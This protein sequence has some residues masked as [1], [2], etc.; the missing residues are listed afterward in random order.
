MTRVATTRPGGP[1]G[2]EAPSAR[3]LWWRAAAISLLAL[4]W[5]LGVRGLNEPD[6][7]RYASVATEMLRSGDWI[8]PRFENKPHLT[9]P[10]LTYWLIALAFRACGVNEWAARLPAALAALGTL[11]LVWSM[12]CRWWGARHAMHAVLILLSTPMFFAMARL[13]DPNMLLTFWVCL[14][15]WAWLTWRHQG[16]GGRRALYY[17]AH[18]LAFLTKGPVGC[19]LIL[20]GQ[21][22]FLRFGGTDGLRRRILWW[23]GLLAAFTVAS[24]WYVLMIAQQ[25]DRTAYF[26]RYELFD[27][28]FTNA[29]G[30]GKPLW[31]FFAVTPLA[32]LPWL[33]LVATFLRRDR[34]GLR[35]AYPELP[36]LALVAVIVAFFT[37]VRSKLPTY[38][39]PAMPPLALLAAAQLRF[40]EERGRSFRGARWIVAGVALLLPVILLARLGPAGIR[41]AHGVHASL[42]VSMVLYVLLA[43]W[44]ARSSPRHW[45]FPAIAM[46]LLAYASALDLIR[47]H[48]HGIFGK[49][50]ADLINTWR[51]TARHPGA[52]F[53]FT[54]AP[55]GLV[56]YLNPEQSPR[57]LTIV[58]KVHPLPSS[59]YVR[60]LAEHLEHLPARPAYVMASSFHLQQVTGSL[61]RLPARPI[62]QDDK[63]TILEVDDPA[64]T[65]PAQGLP[66]DAP[67]GDPGQAALGHGASKPEGRMVHENSCTGRASF[68]G[69]I[70]DGRAPRGPN[71]A[72]PRASG[73]PR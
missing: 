35:G 2:A 63:F 47:R 53:F 9:K 31:F 71:G 3:S 67:K 44:L 43:C 12:A 64:A 5:Q 24:S 57:E 21:L 28:V 4:G 52:P 20:F 22:A 26:L 46:M 54:H 25:P 29:H 39:L 19:L 18:A 50:T 37:V 45:L 48:E 55:A 33:P 41:S 56:F 30:R 69:R 16:G 27:R 13:C 36:L 15:W 14:G 51:T 7:G 34:R 8:V 73:L 6:E 42:V 70:R 72:L 40:D 23:P 38:I 60:Q 49:S 17:A 65:Q 59:E 11:L 58:R 68:P 66:F 32:F 1:P 10:P 61:L 62:A